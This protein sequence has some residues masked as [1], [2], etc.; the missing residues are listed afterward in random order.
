VNDTITSIKRRE[1]VVAHASDVH[2]DDS[3]TANLFGGDGAGPLR[4]VLIAAKKVNADVV[5]LAGD[6]F[7]CHRLPDA[8]IERTAATMREFGLPIV[9]LPGNHDPAIDEAVFH[10]QALR[11]LDLLHILGVTHAEAAHFPELDLEIWGRAHF[12]YSDMDPFATVRERTTR[13]QIAMAHGHHEPV[14][15]RSTRLRASWLIGDDE[16]A[17]TKA[18]YVALGH[19][20]RRVQVGSGDIHAWYS[21]S[22]DYARS[23][24]VVRF[25]GNGTVDVGREHLELPDDFG[26]GIYFD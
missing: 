25:S 24:N 13:W 23:I 8:L 17:A 4:A 9:L 12:D 11:K 1:I 5:M 3:Y 7:E 22:P 26:E 2:I 6:T 19:W 21:G 10:R 18:D 20:N 14:P 16:I 15:D